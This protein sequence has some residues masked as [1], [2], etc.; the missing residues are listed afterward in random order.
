MG[1]YG[2]PMYAPRQECRCFVTVEE[3]GKSPRLRTFT[4]SSFAAIRKAAKSKYPNAKL[5]FG[6]SFWVTL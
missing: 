6:K 4:G 3:P 1:R 2:T 5:S